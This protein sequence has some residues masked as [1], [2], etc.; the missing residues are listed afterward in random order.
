MVTKKAKSLIDKEKKKQH[1]ESKV[2][3]KKRHKIDSD[4][5]F[6]SDE[7]IILDNDSDS[8]TDGENDCIGYGKNY[9]KTTSKED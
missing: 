7:I 5:S 6:N 2:K 3:T 4:I 9:E 1:V 8:G